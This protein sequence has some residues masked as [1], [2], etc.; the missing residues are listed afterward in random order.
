LAGSA[1]AQVTAATLLVVGGADTVVLEMNERAQRALRCRSELVVIPKAGHLFE[2][3]GALEQ[4]AAAATA[5]FAENLEQP[6][7]RMPER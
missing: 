6:S 5:W 1:L 7:E 2:E 4:V 3:P